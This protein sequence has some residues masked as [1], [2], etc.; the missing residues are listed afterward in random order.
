[1]PERPFKALTSLSM[2]GELSGTASGNPHGECSPSLLLTRVPF[3]VCRIIVVGGDGTFNE[4]LNGLMLQ[5]Q[6]A[7]GVNLR[8]SRF[9]PVQTNI[10]LGI[11]PA[12]STHFQ[13]LHP[14]CLLVV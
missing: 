11:I 9:L 8:R 7:A 12:G 13:C 14:F 2:T 5:T 10:R 6:Q 3:L 1:M 4:V